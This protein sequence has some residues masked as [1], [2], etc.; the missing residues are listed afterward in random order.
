MSNLLRTLLKAGDFGKL[1]SF[2]SLQYLVLFLPAVILLY[3]LFPGKTKRYVLLGSSFAF[4][5]L[6]SRKRIVYLLTMILCAY[7]CGLL[8]GWMHTRGNAQVKA[9]EKPERKALK[10][11]WLVR[12]RFVMG[13]AA[14]STIGVLLV[15]KYTWFFFTNVNQF[16][17]THLP[18]PHI[19]QPIGIS[20][21]AL[22]AASYLFDVYRGTLPAERNPL[23]L[24]LFLSFFPQIVEGPICRYSQTAR[25]LWDTKP[26][27]LDD[28]TLGAQRIAYG[29][30]KKLVVAD[31]LNGFVSGVFSGYEAYQGGVIALAAVCYTIQLYMD[32]SGAMDA[33]AG[34]AQIF[35]ITMPENFQRPFFSRTISEFWSR[36]HIS[37]GTWFKDYIFYPV[38]MS[39]PMKN[40]TGIARKRM[41]NHYGPLV[42]GSVALFCVWFSNG[43]WHGAAWSFIFFGM[44]HFTLILTGSLIA[45]AAKWFH[46]ACRI[47]PD[48]KVFCGFQILRT[49]VLVVIGELF[50]RA[51]TLTDGMR[52]F[53]KMVRDFRFSSL[54][55][56]LL[57][58]LNIDAADFTVVAITLVIVLVVS[59][60]NE[61]GIC[62][63]TLLQQ[64]PLVL[65][66]AILYALLFYIIIFGAYGVGYIPVNPM[67]ANF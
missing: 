53:G 35:G 30:M 41:G 33:V 49:C 57:A 64:K 15:V 18:L 28:L 7:L 32:F 23:R 17:G 48:N 13:L 45:P 9:A 38:T 4:F 47:S 8:L 10:A 50:F 51:D 16:F 3:S 14:L 62:V 43:L 58:S 46:S 36:W 1:T 31:R 55:A 25:Q 11:R 56:G 34:T 59:I 40:L 39:K 54:D 6:I 26:I 29:L 12:R 5:Y 24:A 65:R 37:L 60:L 66:W 61:R 27:R 44:Y 67:Y 42:A 22:Q 52:M 20:F 2:F 19:I 63:R 21:F